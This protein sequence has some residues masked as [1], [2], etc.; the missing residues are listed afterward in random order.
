MIVKPYVLLWWKN[1][2]DDKTYI[3]LKLLDGK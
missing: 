1:I 3:I 2:Y